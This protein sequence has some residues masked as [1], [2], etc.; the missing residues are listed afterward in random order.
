MASVQIEDVV[1][2]FRNRRTGELRIQP[3]ARDKF[4]SQPFGTPI[5]LPAGTTS[6]RLRDAVLENLSKNQ[7]RKY[8]KE[9]APKIS[10]EEY[11]R[12]LLEDDLV[13]VARSRS[14]YRILPF[15]KM[16]KSFGSVDNLMVTAT[17]EEFSSRGGELIEGVFASLT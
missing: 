7:T 9:R 8:S 15:R 6:A 4:S 16:K 12:R 14:I 1:E 2:I 3:F 5:V 10:D 11:E 17:E 13:S